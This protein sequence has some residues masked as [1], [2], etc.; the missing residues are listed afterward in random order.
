MV[1][2]IQRLHPKIYKVLQTY[3]SSLFKFSYK[4]TLI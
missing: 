2:T 4:V 1:T 3:K